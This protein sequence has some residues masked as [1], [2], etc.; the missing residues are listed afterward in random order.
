MRNSIVRKIGLLLAVLI[1]AGS[2]QTEALARGRDG[3]RSFHGGAFHHDFGHGFRRHFRHH[4]AFFVYYDFPHYY[5]PYYPSYPY[6]P[7]GYYNPRGQ[8]LIA[9]NASS[10]SLMDIADMASRGVPDDEIINEIKRTRSTFHLNSE[11]ITY[12]KENGASDKV[13]DYMLSTGNTAQY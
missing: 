1:L 12:L 10:L 3:S 8:D 2:N 6:Y 9:N 13:I 7:Y 5:Y 11:L 4:N